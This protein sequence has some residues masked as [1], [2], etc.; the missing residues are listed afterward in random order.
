MKSIVTRKRM[1]GSQSWMGRTGIP[2]KKLLLG[3]VVFL[4][5]ASRPLQAQDNDRNAPFLPTP[6][7][8]VSTV[9]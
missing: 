8:S 1:P 9:P 3:A 6:V 2:L 7:R 4:A 5:M